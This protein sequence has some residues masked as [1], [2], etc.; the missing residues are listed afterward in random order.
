ML[1]R[2]LTSLV[3]LLGCAGA[4]RGQYVT[5]TGTLQASNGMPAQNYVISFTPSQFGFI[6]GTSVVVNTSTYCATSTDGSVAGVP[7]PLVRPPVTV[8]FTG[9][10]PPAN[11]YVK[12]AFYD[13]NSNV[14]L[15]SPE[16]VIQLNST[17]RLIVAAPVAGMPSGA[18]GM[19]VYI[20]TSTNAETLQ[21]SSTG[22]AAYLQT[23]PLVTG[24]AAPASNTTICKQVANDAIWPSGTGY[25]VALTDPSGNTLPG[26][27]MMWQLMGP[28]GTI[29]LS[30]GLPYYNGTVYFPT[31][32]LASPL[33][34]GLQSIS[35][36]LSLTNYNLT[37]VGAIGVGTSLP[38]WPIDV[39]NGAINASGGFILNGGAGVT[40]A[41]CLLAGSDP[42]HTFNV[43]G[44][45]LTSVTAPFAGVGVP[46]ATSTTTS[47]VATSPQLVTALN[48][49]PSSTLSP[50]LLPLATTG[51][52]GAV[53]PDG[54]T[55]TV[56]GGVIT[57]ATVPAVTQSANLSGSK[58]FGASYQNTSGLKMWVSAYGA[59]GGSGTSEFSC[60]DGVS[61]PSAI[62]AAIQQNATAGSTNSGV[63]CLIPPSY[64][65]EITATGT[66]APGS[67]AGWFE[68]TF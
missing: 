53:K 65:Y 23:V 35:G 61:S 4:A 2:W 26:Y 22:S 20:A 58:A 55:I 56:S 40:M 51:A 27:P 19:R 38:A 36:P 64:Y 49:T 37:N 11:Y 7:N 46:Y 10:L 54:T 3:V 63:S 21:G 5:L 66:A 12:F 67:P 24:T 17:G 1:R 42:Y 45:C 33:N 13:A 16:T 6:G 8:G 9:S 52:F 50:A 30:N 60:L 14:T 39:E 28:N 48:N 47:T 29:N 68:T 41:Q 25:T 44:N 62:I 31:P 18:T 34:H 59:T 57:A 15:V 32:I 43:A